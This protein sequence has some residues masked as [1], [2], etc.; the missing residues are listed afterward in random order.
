M[1]SRPDFVQPARRSNARQSNQACNKDATSRECQNSANAAERLSEMQEF[2]RENTAVEVRFSE[3]PELQYSLF[4][5]TC[6]FVVLCDTFLSGPFRFG[7]QQI[8]FILMLYLHDR[9]FDTRVT[10]INSG[11]STVS[12]S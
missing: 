1:I 5:P 7:L 8:I 10:T 6:N 3:D 11:Q 12:S 4:F 9:I 2:I